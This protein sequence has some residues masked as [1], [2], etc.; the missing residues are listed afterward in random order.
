MYIRQCELDGEII[1][2]IC[3]NVNG[4]VVFYLLFFLIFMIDDSSLQLN[5]YSNKMHGCNSPISHPMYADDVVI[6]PS[7]SAGLQMFHGYGLD[8]D[9]KYNAKMDNVMIG[10]RFEERK[11]PLPVW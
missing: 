11:L 5:G 9:I 7:C 8:F 4:K 3:S 6:S 10:K 1:C 2:L